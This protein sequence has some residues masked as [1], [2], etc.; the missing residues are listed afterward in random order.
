M[1]Q[2]RSLDDMDEPAARR[3]IQQIIEEARSSGT[4]GPRSPEEI[5]K[6]VYR[7]MENYI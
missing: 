6:E 4:N 7:M 1:G 5:E 3:R 2:Y